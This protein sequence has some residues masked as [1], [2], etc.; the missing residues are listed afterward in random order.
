MAIPY[1]AQPTYLKN[2]EIEPL[3]RTFEQPFSHV[4]LKSTSYTF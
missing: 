4:K 3:S 2:V 1:G